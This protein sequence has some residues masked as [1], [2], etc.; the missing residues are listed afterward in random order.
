ME[1]F[2]IPDIF[3]LQTSPEEERLGFKTIAISLS[4]FGPADTDTLLRV[5]ARRL[6]D[7]DISLKMSVN[8]QTKYRLMRHGYTKRLGFRTSPK[9]H[10]LQEDLLDKADADTS[11]IQSKI[12]PVPCS[13]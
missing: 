3:P 8:G 12:V 7:S 2:E 4:G 1:P 5:V 10:P 9:W 6:S 11:G 13:L